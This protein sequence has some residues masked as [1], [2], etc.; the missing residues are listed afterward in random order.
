MKPLINWLTKTMCSLSSGCCRKTCFFDSLKNNLKNINGV[1]QSYS[2][3]LSGYF[4]ILVPQPIY[5]GAEGFWV[6]TIG[7]II[8][9][10][11]VGAIWGEDKWIEEW[12]KEPGYNDP[13][14]FEEYKNPPPKKEMETYDPE[15]EALNTELTWWEHWEEFWYSQWWWPRDEESVYDNADALDTP[16]PEL[17]PKR[18]KDTRTWLVRWLDNATAELCKKP[19]EPT[20]KEEDMFDDLWDWTVSLYKKITAPAPESPNPSPNT[21]SIPSNQKQTEEEDEYE[22]ETWVEAF[23]NFIKDRW[24]WRSIFKDDETPAWHNSYTSETDDD[25]LH[26]A[27]DDDDDRIKNFYFSTADDDDDDL[28]EDYEPSDYRAILVVVFLIG[29]MI[30]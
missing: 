12:L 17:L 9:I 19:P 30:V 2:H 5:L 29:V 1:K 28:G 10:S 24:W 11:F 25:E 21:D 7:V 27:D 18:E 4:L 3:L 20:T 14:E 13:D 8:G 23:T 15:A 22:P 16:P 26:N 6:L